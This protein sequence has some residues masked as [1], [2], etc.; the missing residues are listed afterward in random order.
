MRLL[1]QEPDRSKRVSIDIQQD[2]GIRERIWSFLVEHG[3]GHTADG[4]LVI[5]SIRQEEIAARVGV[6]LHEV[7]R[8][9]HE[10][11]GDGRIDIERQD[12][13]LPNRYLLSGRSGA[14]DAIAV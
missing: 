2:S 1:F 9:I 5:N 8:A 3:R 11:T 7:I 12:A 10:L 14:A 6:P 13:G 4:K